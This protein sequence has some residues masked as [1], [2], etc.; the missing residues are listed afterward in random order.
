M[1]LNLNSVL[2]LTQLAAPLLEAST[3]SLRCPVMPCL[4]QILS[5]IITSQESQCPYLVHISSTCNTCE[6]MARVCTSLW[7]TWVACGSK[8][9]R[10]HQQWCC[11]DLLYMLAQA[12]HGSIVNISSVGGQRCAPG[13]TAYCV[14][15]A[16]VDML[17]KASAL[18][19][20]PKVGFYK[21]PSG[22]MRA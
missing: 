1:N 8:N 9:A 2:Y 21:R 4:A 7:G 12:S 20:A 10:R 16:A 22:P 11:N 6:T 5:W 17:T 15:K 19:L 3:R 14:A 18:E 13:A